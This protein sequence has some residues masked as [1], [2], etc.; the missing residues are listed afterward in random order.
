MYLF[1]IIYVT[2]LMCSYLTVMSHLG[3]IL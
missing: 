3:I 1:Y 2:F